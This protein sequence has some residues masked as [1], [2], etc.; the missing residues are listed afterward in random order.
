MTT[1][2]FDALRHS[3]LG[4]TL[5][6]NEVD[7]VN[8]ILT[9]MAGD[10]TS[11]I[12]YA[13]ATVYHETAGTM[14]PIKERGGAAYFTRMYDVTG[15]SP[16]RA[17]KHGNMDPGDGPR[18]CGRGYVQLTWKN[19]YRKVGEAIGLD[20]V[21]QPDLALDPEIAAMILSGGMREGWFTGKAFED[22]FRSE[23]ADRH[24]FVNARHIINGLDRAD[25]IADYALLFQSALA[26]AEWSAEKA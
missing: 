9:A 3:P 10:P 22:Y 21:A 11:W 18:Y 14:Q 8:V 19:N 20:L 4:P 16:D 24:Q 25:D 7:G 15:A 12:A 5:E 17:R 26:A 13:L 2:L 23:L 1:K 6:Q